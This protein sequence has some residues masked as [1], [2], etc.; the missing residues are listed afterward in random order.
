[1]A[2]MPAY[3]PPLSAYVLALSAMPAEI[4]EFSKFSDISA[5]PVSAAAAFPSLSAMPANAVPAG[6]PILP[7]PVW[8]AALPACTALPSPLPTPVPTSPVYTCVYALSAFLRQAAA[9]PGRLLC[10]SHVYL[11]VMNNSCRGNRHAA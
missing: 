5:M 4:P 2:A 7:S 9:I 3:M 8:T 6:G 1:M 11:P 10:L